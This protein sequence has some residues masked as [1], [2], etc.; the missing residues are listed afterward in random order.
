MYYTVIKH[1]GHLRPQRKCRKHELQVSVFCISTFL[2]YRGNVVFYVKYSD[3]TWV[4]DQSGCAQGPVHI[5]IIG[6]NKYLV[7]AEIENCTL[8]YRPCSFLF[9]LWP[10]CEAWV[11]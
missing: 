3:K 7:L 9:N 6:Y 11:P 5:I 8:S 1:D 4:F 2:E 10:K